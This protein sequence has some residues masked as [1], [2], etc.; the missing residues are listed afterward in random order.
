[1]SVGQLLQ[2]TYS[3][4]R[5]LYRNRAFTGVAAASLVVGIA[6]ATTAFSIFDAL[7]LNSL[8]YPN[9]DRLVYLQERAPYWATPELGVSSIDLDSWRKLSGSFVDIAG[10]METGEDLAGL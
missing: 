9:A 7:F 10:F 3:A 5:L 6:A 1:M 8:P 4:L 2:D